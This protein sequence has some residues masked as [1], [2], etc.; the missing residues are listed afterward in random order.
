MA[1]EKVYHKL[2]EHLGEWVFGAPESEFL[3]PL[4]KLR[5]T[6]E[7][8][9]LLSQ[10]PYLPH[11]A[12]QLAE[13]LNKPVEELRDNLEEF[14]QQGIVNRSEGRNAIRYTSG[15]LMF[16]FYRMPWWSGKSEELDRKLAPLANNYYIDAYAADYM[17]YHTKGLRAVPINQTIEDTREIMPY[18]DILKIVENAE[19]YSVSHCACRQRHNLDPQFEECKHETENCLHFDRLGRYTVDQGVGREIT[20]EETLEILA[21]AADDGLVHGVSTTKVGVDTICNCCADCCLLLESIV[22]MPGLVP[23]GHNRSSY[24]REIDEEKCIKCGLCAKKCPM[25][26]IEFDKEDKILTFNLDRC[27]GCGVCAHKCPKN[28]I[29]L[30]HRE[31]EDEEYPNNPREMVAKYI[32][33]RGRDPAEVFKKRSA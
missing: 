24:V 7:E 26:A 22:K 16:M 29:Y 9:E 3:I 10:I 30:A 8:A 17:G 20:K 12:E 13:K 14:A 2:I 27:I 33:E 5:F 32:E 23:R 31:G 11:T 25:G 4:L 28:A 15:D 6:P 1:E 21:K 19:F 18:E